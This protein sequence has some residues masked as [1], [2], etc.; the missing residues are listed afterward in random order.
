MIA[1]RYVSA[2]FVSLCWFECLGADD[3]F[4]R[5]YVGLVNTNDTRPTAVHSTSVV[6]TNNDHP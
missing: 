1:Q 4:F 5:H 3:S 2:V 6:D